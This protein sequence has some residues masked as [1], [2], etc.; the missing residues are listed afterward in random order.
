[1]EKLYKY[2]YAAGEILLTIYLYLISYFYTLSVPLSW[3]A[4]IRLVIIYA[5]VHFSLKWLS[6]RKIVLRDQPGKLN[7]K[8][9]GV[10]FLISAGILGLYYAAYYPGGICSDS[11]NQW[12]QVEDGY[13]LDWHPAI[14]TFLFLKLPSLICESLSF[15]NLAQLIWISLASAYLAMTMEKWGIR[16]RW[17]IIAMALAIGNP[18]SSTILSFCWKDT[19]LTIFVMVLTAQVMEVV[20]TEGKS[21]YDWRNLL[22]L[23]VSGGLASLMRHNGILL[24]GPLLVLMVLICWKKAGKRS[25]LAGI[26]TL[27]VIAGIKGPV[28]RVL[29]VQSHP[30]VS[31]EMLGVPMTILAN[32]LVNEPELLDEEC[33]EFMYRIGDQALWEEKYR[34]GSWNSAKWMGDD[35]SNDV[36]EEVGAANILKYTWHAVLRAPYLSYRA[37]VKL[38]EV[39]WKPG[40]SE[41]AWSYHVN[42]DENNIYGMVTGG[43]PA[44][45]KILDTVHDWSTK[46]GVLL[47]WFWYTGFYILLLLFAGLSQLKKGF[48]KCLYWVPVMAYNFGTAL[49][50]C[51]SDFRFF[52]FNTVV[53]FPMVL[54]ILGE[55]RSEAEE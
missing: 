38:F 24:V 10:I 36:M 47:T 16:K 4:P 48:A 33:R 29:H 39:V 23:A 32:V 37:A 25:L 49:L 53:T 8:F 31:A 43:V 44:L 34:E 41:V 17:C 15:V 26:L 45:Q 2:V 42:V 27:A 30:Q 6:G 35:I 40:G 5:A 14:H 19:A 28:Y 21:L 55:R 20:C 52:A 22:C 54:M 3:T 51:G 13:L 7:W 18:A 50:L 9:G 11:F 1:M 12:Y 46:G